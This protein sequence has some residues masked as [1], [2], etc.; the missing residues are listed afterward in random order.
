MSYALY[1]V[2]SAHGGDGIST[3]VLKFHS[4]AAMVAAKEAL[5]EELNTWG[6]GVIARFIMLEEVA[7]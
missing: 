7:D 2:V 1:V 3:N 6:T 4:R 5:N